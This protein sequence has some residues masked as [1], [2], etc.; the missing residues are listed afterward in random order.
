MNLTN[1]LLQDIAVFNEN[2]STKLE[3]W[4]MDIETTADLTNESWAKLAKAKSRGLTHILV[5]EAINYDKSWDKI[6]DLLWLKLCST[7]IHTYT[8]CFMDIQQWEKQSLAAYIH[9]FKME[10]KRCNFTNNAATIRIF[11]RNW[12]MPI[13]WLHTSMKRDLKCSLMPSWKWRSLQLQSSH[14]SWST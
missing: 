7:N 9:R 13:V 2:D 10:A 8:S 3:D 4:L 11:V 6:K 1:S 14:L 12:G 5:M